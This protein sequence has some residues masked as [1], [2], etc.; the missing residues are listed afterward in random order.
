[1]EASRV[2]FFASGGRRGLAQSIFQLGGNAG[3][4]V[5]P[6]LVALVVM[7]YGQSHIAWF[8]LAALLGIAV[9]MRLGAWY[10]DHLV[11]RASGRVTVAEPDHG[12][13]RRKVILSLAVLLLLIFSKYIYLTSITSYFT[14][15]LIDQFGLSIREAQ[16]HLF[17]FLAS[18]AIGT[19]IGGPL[20]DRFGRK[21]II[22]I[23]ILG[24]APFT[25]LMPYANLFWTT[26]LSV[27]IGLILSSAFS[28]ILVYAQE[29]VP[30]KVGMISGL[31]FGFA[32]GMAGI[33]SALLGWLADATSIAHVYRLCAFLPLLG[34]FTAFLPNIRTRKKTTA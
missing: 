3:S 13:P 5:G 7:P 6:L 18:V 2:A 23:S 12:L 29:L 32:F 15:Y 4:A 27:C 33:G 16:L 21:Y 31:F 26:I 8:L 1:P 25:L 11:L 34:I 28:A 20:G 30:G 14:F 19:V 9:L 22:W 10:R 17:F 24:V